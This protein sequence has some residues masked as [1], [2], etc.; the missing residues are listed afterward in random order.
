MNAAKII[1]HELMEMD[2][3]SIVVLTILISPFSVIFI[4]KECLAVLAMSL[5]GGW[6]R[7]HLI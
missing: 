1:T 7:R 4:I 6:A 2:R 3:T 5:M